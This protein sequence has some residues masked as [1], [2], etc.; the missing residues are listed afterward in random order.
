MVIWKSLS[1]NLAFKTCFDIDI[2]FRSDTIDAG[3][4]YFC[5]ICHFQTDLNVA[6]FM[7]LVVGI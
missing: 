4:D 6:S 1:H 7:I 5:K 2:D 3:N